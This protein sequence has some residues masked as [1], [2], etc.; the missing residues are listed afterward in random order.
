MIIRT[1]VQEDS[2]SLVQLAAVTPMQG[3]ISVCIQRMPDFFLLLKRKGTPFTILA[4]EDNMIVGCVSVI[5][6]KMMIDATPATVQYCCDLKVHPDFRERKVATKLCYAMHDHLQASRPDLVFST[7]AEGNKKVMPLFNGKSG[8]KGVTS[9]GKFHILQLVP[10][11]LRNK[12][13][14]IMLSDQLPQKVL[15]FYKDYATTYVMHPI[16]DE[17]TFSGCTHM[18]ME[19][20]GEPVAAVSLYDASALKQNVLAGIPWY[21]K[22]AVGTLKIGK[23]L[24]STPHLPSVGESIGMLYVKTFAVRQRYEPLLHLLIKAASDHAY[25]SGYSFLS[26]TFHEEDTLMNGFRKMMHFPFVAI[27]M[28]CTVDGDLQLLNKLKGKKIYEDFSLI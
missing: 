24:F 14:D 22:L 6:K 12:P 5:T 25:R 8:L 9:T 7:V 1:A 20:A 18:W 16:V 3:T 2:D 27:G 26:I 11:P 15:S 21:F 10:R 28:A 17:Q 23:R 4:E 19:E 13:E